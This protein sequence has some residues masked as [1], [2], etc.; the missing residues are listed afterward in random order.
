MVYL[1]AFEIFG[2][3]IIPKRYTRH[4]K[5]ERVVANAWNTQTHAIALGLYAAAG[6]YYFA[7]TEK[8]DS[9]KCR[10]L[11]II[12][13]YFGIDATEFQPNIIIIICWKIVF[14]LPLYFTSSLLSLPSLSAHFLV[15]VLVSYRP[16][17]YRNTRHKATLQIIATTT[18]W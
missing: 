6:W 4:T 13:G 2:I 8:P 16:F 18:I 3:I 5:G 7:C 17:A 10:K 1:F 9:N 15:D 11:H 14:E 12:L